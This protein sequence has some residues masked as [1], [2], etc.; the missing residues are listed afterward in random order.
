MKVVVC[1]DGT[2]FFD[3]IWSLIERNKKV[4]VLVPMQLGMGKNIENQEYVQQLHQVFKFSNNVGL[5]AGHS[6]DNAVYIFGSYK[7]NF[8]FLDPHKINDCI[9]IT[10]ET[11]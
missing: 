8:L 10:K 7:D 2:I 5:I 3:Q 6:G 1:R 9:P 4:L 11:W